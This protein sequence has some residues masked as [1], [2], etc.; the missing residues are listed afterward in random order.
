MSLGIGRGG[1]STTRPCQA[2]LHWTAIYDVPVTLVTGTNGK[3]TTV[4][5]VGAIAH[6]AGKAPG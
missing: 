6:A 5:L 4:R 1:P 2:G 3:T